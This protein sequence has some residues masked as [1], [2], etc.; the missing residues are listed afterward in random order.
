MV[1]PRGVRVKARDAYTISR[2]R[3]V[4]EQLV[5]RGIKDKRLL[6]AISIVPRHLFV[7]EGFTASAYG[8][9]ALPIGEKQTITQPYMVAFMIERLGLKG[10]EKVLDIGSGSGY[11]SA[12]LSLLAGR[13]FCME[14]ISRI[15]SK[16]RRLL[17]ELHCANVVLRVGDGTLGWREEAP[18]DAIIISA[19]GPHVP[20]ALLTQLRPGGRLIMP[21]GAEFED[22]H[23][24]LVT[25][26]G[27]SF[28][29]V[30]LGPCRFV[31]LLGKDG[32]PAKKGN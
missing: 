26:R 2:E 10:T 32:W 23:L 9:H 19:S 20:T 13:V 29:Q 5:G 18:F 14:R 31:K 12:V 16:S 3:M 25:R 28:E 17:D 8:D 1:N 4:A 21:V 22:Q 15:A 7:A 30:D 6:K 24:I 11:Q 27:S